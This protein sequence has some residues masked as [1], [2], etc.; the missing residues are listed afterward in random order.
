MGKMMIAHQKPQAQPELITQLQADKL[1]TPEHGKSPQLFLEEPAAAQQPPAPPL[2]AERSPAVE[3]TKKTRTVQDDIDEDLLPVFL[4]E[5]NDLYLQLGNTLRAWRT[6][7][8]DEGLSHNLQRTLHT[9][10]GGARTV[11]AMR[12]GALTHHTED[13][14][15]QTG[16]QHDAAFWNELDN[17]FGRIGSALDQLRSGAPVKTGVATKLM[18]NRMVPFS[19]IGDRLYRIVRQTGRELGKNANLELIGSELHLDRS[20]LEKMTAP[21]EHLLRNAMVHGLESAEERSRKGKSPTGS[22]RLTLRQENNGVEFEFTDDGAG[23]DI[24]R[25][26]SKAIERGLLQAD[27]GVS[28][29]EIMQL[30]FSSGLSTA[31]EVTEISGRGVGMDVVRSEINAL[32]GYID[33]FSERDKGARFVIH[34][35]LTL[36]AS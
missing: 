34:L 22:I 6:Q 16:V 12:I 31:S 18:A 4:E 3:P 28:E 17:Y 32:G 9:L 33:V 30:I 11:G 36:A 21:F 20:M 19:S 2:P 23:L 29:S 5:G 1:L 35:P 27:T 15:I 26:R 25:L 24:E 8:D 7:P 10:K 13:H 14:V